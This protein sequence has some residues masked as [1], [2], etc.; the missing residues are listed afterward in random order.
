MGFTFVGNG[1][2]IFSKSKPQNRNTGGQEMTAVN[3]S[4]PTETSK[5]TFS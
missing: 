1:E 2:N 4:V 3:S 5:A